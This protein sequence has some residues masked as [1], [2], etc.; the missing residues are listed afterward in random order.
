M[1]SGGPPT[2]K[3]PEMLHRPSSSKRFAT[4]KATDGKV[5][6]CPIG[7]TESQ[8]GEIVDCNKRRQKEIRYREVATPAEEAQRGLREE[9]AL[10]ESELRKNDDWLDLQGCFARLQPKYQEVIALKYFDD[11]DIRDIACIPGKPEGTVKSL[12]HRGI[13]H[14]RKMM[15][16]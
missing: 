5:S 4:S 10:A 9:I 16:S 14:L 13:E 1:R 8:T 11:K 2:S 6:P 3:W 7:C 12:I 15:E